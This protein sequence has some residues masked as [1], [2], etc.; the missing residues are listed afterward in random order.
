MNHIETAKD[1]ELLSVKR[2]QSV[3]FY[4]RGTARIVPTADK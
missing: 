2:P 1:D 3:N 4:M